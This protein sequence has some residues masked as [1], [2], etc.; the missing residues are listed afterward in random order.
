MLSWVSSKIDDQHRSFIVN[1][2]D[3]QELILYYSNGTFERLT[4]LYARSVLPSRLTSV[5]HQTKKLTCLT[6]TIVDLQSDLSYLQRAKN[7][8]ECFYQIDLEQSLKTSTNYWK[9]NLN[10]QQTRLFQ[11]NDLS[12]FIFCRRSSNDVYL[13]QLNSSHSWKFVFDSSQ[14][15]TSVCQ[16]ILVLFLRLRS[17]DNLNQVHY[18]FGSPQILLGSNE[19]HF[20]IETY[21]TQH[22]KLFQKNSNQQQQQQFQLSI[23]IRNASA[24]KMIEHFQEI[25]SWKIDRVQIECKQQEIKIDTD[26]GLVDSLQVQI[27]LFSSSI[28]RLI[29]IYSVVEQFFDGVDDKG[30]VKQT[31][32]AQCLSL[33]DVCFFCELK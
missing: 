12:L 33:I 18:R 24:K 25:R 29:V 8:L 21:F 7:K 31:D 9:L 26:A 1:Y 16:P 23:Q 13:F 27:N 14:I 15:G 19:Q 2:L 32:V 30:L 17:S 28:Q 10:E 20:P 6:R 4:N 11:P 3:G 5:S 22:C